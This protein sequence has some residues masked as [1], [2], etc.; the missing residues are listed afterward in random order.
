MKKH[1]KNDYPIRTLCFLIE[2]GKIPYIQIMKRF[3]EEINAE[4]S[5]R[6]SKTPLGPIKID[7]KIRY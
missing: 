6:D 2:Q 7:D 3:A 4:W 1:S 5:H